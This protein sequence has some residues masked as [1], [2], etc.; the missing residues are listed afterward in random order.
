MIVSVLPAL[1]LRIVLADLE[2]AVADQQL[3]L[4]CPAHRGPLTSV[5]AELDL[6]DL[7]LLHVDDAQPTLVAEEV[8]ID[9]QVAPVGANGHRVGVLPQAAPAGEGKRLAAEPLTVAR[10]PPFDPIL[11]DGCELVADEPNGEDRILFGL[12]VLGG[13]RELR[14]SLARAGPDL[15]GTETALSGNEAAVW[16][17]LYPDDLEDRG[18]RVF[19]DD[20]AAL[21]VQDHHCAAVVVVRVRPVLGV[22]DEQL[23][24]IRR[25]G[26]GVGLETVEP[27][28]P[29]RLALGRIVDRDLALV[30]GPCHSVALGRHRDEVSVFAP[31]DAVW[32]R[33][34]SQAGIDVGDFG[35]RGK[36]QG[37]ARR[38]DHAVD[39]PVAVVDPAL[40]DLDLVGPAA[41][42]VRLGEE[43]RKPIL[44]P[45][46]RTGLGFGAGDAKPDHES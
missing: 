25:E 1:Q 26:H 16:A 35:A 5:I 34:E 17:R 43:R 32:L 18:I 28:I 44:V 27:M 6:L 42:L 14:H 2:V 9:G 24:A 12:D 31:E 7:L 23:P 30:V 39:R 45:A 21:G 10:V 29:V 46:D 15:A 19:P 11:P 4:R 20:L 13:V 41:E 36:G 3:A 8:P 38:A 40:R 33:D 37:A 22:A